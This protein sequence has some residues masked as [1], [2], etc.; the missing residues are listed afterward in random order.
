VWPADSSKA[1]D[2]DGDWFE[3]ERG[4]VLLRSSSGT[5]FWIF[6]ADGRLSESYAPTMHTDCEY[7]WDVTHEIR[8]DALLQMASQWNDTVPDGFRGTKSQRV[9]RIAGP[10]ERSSAAVARVRNLL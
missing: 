9:C 4:R 3:L 7:H 1:P 5:D 2:S 10:L 6:D 8:D